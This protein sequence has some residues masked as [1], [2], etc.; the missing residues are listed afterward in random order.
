M[1]AHP[2]LIVTL[3][4]F[5]AP[6]LLVA[7]D[8]EESLYIPPTLLIQD[9]YPRGSRVNVERLDV[10][11][12]P[13]FSFHDYSH[14]ESLSLLPIIFFDHPGD[15][16]LPPRYRLTTD[17]RG[18]ADTADH[19]PQV[20][21][22]GKYYELLDIVGY[23]MTRF[24]ATAVTLRPGY[25]AE[26]GE[27]PDVATTRADVIRDYLTTTW[28]VDP[29]RITIARPEILSAVDDILPRHEEARCVTIETASWE[30]IRPVRYTTRQRFSQSLPLFFIIDPNLSPDQV[31]TITIVMSTHEGIVGHDS[32]P[33]HPAVETYV[34]HGEWSGGKRDPRTFEHALSVEAIVTTHDGRV[35]RSNRMRIETEV[36]PGNPLDPFPVK[37]IDIL[38]PFFGF[39]DGTLNDYHRMMLRDIIDSIAPMG[40]AIVETESQV[41]LSEETLTDPI[42]KDLFYRQE[43]AEQES[44]PVMPREPFS[45][46]ELHL[47]NPEWVPDEPLSTGSVGRTRRIDGEMTWHSRNVLINGSDSIPSIYRLPH[48]RTTSVVDFI[49]DSLNLTIVNETWA[50]GEIELQKVRSSYRETGGSD[51][52]R[53]EDRWYGRSVRV[54]LWGEGGIRHYQGKYEKSDEDDEDDDP[55]E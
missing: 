15:W 11:D 54:T 51:F 19:W 45:S 42:E 48:T 38:L 29:N 7:Q 44:G 4:T 50:P 17:V 52:L 2:L 10:D 32:V 5:L 13:R 41:E 35:R 34:L 37:S 16:N 9:L 3:V 12:G 31:A 18:Y 8:E 23:R 36:R 43:K 33:G 53:P 40:R 1:N 25:S 28:K 47:A 27:T 21:E 49:R 6:L 14:E 24:P 46:G 55:D 39:R 22:G 20:D 30:L 26:P